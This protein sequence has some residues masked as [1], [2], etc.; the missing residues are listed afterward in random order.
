MTVQDPRLKQEMLDNFM[1]RAERLVRNAEGVGG[2]HSRLARIATHAAEQVIVHGNPAFVHGLTMMK[3][4]PVTIE[5]FMES[6]EFLGGVEYDIWP[7][8][9]QDVYEMNPD[10]MAGEPAV[11][12]VYLGGATGTGKT[13]TGSATIM[14]Q[15]YM[16]T[17]FEKPQKL[18]GLS[19][20]TPIVFMLQS[21]S[22]TVT[23]RVI[24]TPLRNAITNMRY[25]QKHV[26]FNKY[27]EGELQ[28]EQEI[29]IIPALASLQSILGQAVCGALLDEVNF[30]TIVENSKRA[31]GPAGLGGKFD[32][33]EETYSNISR[34]RKRS[35]TT[36]GISIGCIVAASSTRYKDD[37]LDRR[38]DQSI[39][40]EEPNVIH[41]RHA[42]FHVNPK[43][44][45][46]ALFGGTFQIAVGND[47]Q[48]TTVIEEGM[49]PGVHYP[50]TAQIMDIPMPYKPDFQKNPDAALRDIVGIATDAISP[51]IRKRQKIVDAIN[52]GTIRAIPSMVEKDDVELATDGMPVLNR[53]YLMRLSP[54]QRR[55]PRWVHVDLSRNKD[56]CGIGMVAL[57]GFVASRVGD[58]EGIAAS[59]PKFTVELAVGIKP[60]AVAEIDIADVRNWVMQLVAVY[61]LN[62]AGISFD[63]FDSRETIQ[64]L[65]KAGIRAKA[66]SLDTSPVPYEDF[67]D[68]LYEDRIDIQ[69]DCELLS[70]EL[71]TLEF[72]PQ[73]NKVDHPPRGTK[74]VSDGVAGAVANALRSRIVRTG[75]HLD[76]DSEDG[77]HE[78]HRGEPER[79]PHGQSVPRF[80]VRRETVKVARDRSRR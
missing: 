75:I 16:L 11:H 34:R 47:E 79:D 77:W 63:G 71:R 27:V 30:M 10:V 78:N 45:D 46:P 51:F 49:L 70:V 76:Q 54:A 60:S 80:R 32:Q 56:R 19:P 20:T 9:K 73:K 36:R 23:K 29:R 18:F 38:I 3:H 35:F 64:T 44:N 8:L 55:K 25:F 42:Q 26:P 12:E 22:P 57:E 33:A 24:Y 67:R 7:A 52:R 50:A 4:L 28:M 14:Y 66:L 61:G 37:F 5:E 13:F 40:F 21:V 15:A 58:V 41:F 68:A 72:Y 62:I 2:P 59:L 53:D 74:D 1:R 65:N 6:N 69:P 31:A 17:C 39:K 48:G 43:F